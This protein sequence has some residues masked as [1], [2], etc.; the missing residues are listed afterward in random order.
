[1]GSAQRIKLYRAKF[2][3]GKLSHYLCIIS[4]TIVDVEKYEIRQKT[5]KTSVCTMSI[6]ST[7]T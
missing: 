3:A 4:M 7:E 1:M 6:T 2:G 5:D